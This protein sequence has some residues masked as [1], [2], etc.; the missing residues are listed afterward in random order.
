MT[1]DVLTAQIQN[2]EGK[3]KK[4]YKTKTSRNLS[5]Q[6]GLTYQNLHVMNFKQFLENS[7]PFERLA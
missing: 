1:E 4:Q 7:N 5:G 6:K 3:Y 2:E